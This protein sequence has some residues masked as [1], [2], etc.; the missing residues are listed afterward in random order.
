VDSLQTVAYGG[1]ER[2]RRAPP[3]REQIAAGNQGETLLGRYRLIEHLGS[4]GFAAV[5]RAHDERLDREVAVK[6]IP[7]PA[8]R[9]MGRAK[10]EA[11]ATARLSH[12]AIV[13]LLEAHPGPGEF[14]LVSELVDGD[15]LRDLIAEDALCD[16][17]ILEIG[18]ALTAALEHAHARGV[19]HRDVK[20][21]NVL[22]PA[23]SSSDTAIAK[24]AD[25]G[26]ASLVGEEALTLTGDVLGTLAYMAPEQSEGLRAGPQADL[27][28]LALLLY[29]AFTGANPVR[30]ATPAE[31]ARRLGQPITPL[32]RERADLPLTLS[33]T[34]GRALDPDPARRGTVAQLRASLEDVAGELAGAPAQKTSGASRAPQRAAALVSYPRRERSADFGERPRPRWYAL[35]RV[36]WW[37]GAVGLIGWQLAVGHA[38]VALLFSAGALPLLALPRRSTPGFLIGALAPAFGFVG[39]AGA[40]PA[41]FG[42]ASRWRS[43]AYLAVLGYWWLELAEPLSP[44]RLWL[45]VPPDSLPRGAWEGSVQLSAVHVIYPLLG[46]GVVLGCMLWAGAC[47]VLPWIVRGRS[48]AVDMVA[49]TLWAGALAL[50]EYRLA[51]G[52]TGHSP[53]TTPHGLIVSAI[54]CG[55]LAVGARAI[56]TPL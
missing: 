8:D 49:A 23:R 13:A 34:L 9:D 10:R 56:R 48:A 5:W 37:A 15:T 42:Q 4:G 24:L 20:P 43:R 36:C 25:F 33:D 41:V 18:L 53:A 54:A 14:Y 44:H 28:S 46:L 39:L 29:E 47:T 2:S 1:S 38:G 45:G 6:R 26:G 19:I 52:F 7:L 35:P 27:Y 40:C 11:K 16:E 31:T 55:I 22:V 50:G 17:D 51:H 3:A 32:R 21:Q 30:G 12:P